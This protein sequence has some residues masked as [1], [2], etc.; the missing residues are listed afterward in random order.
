MYWLHYRWVTVIPDF[1]LNFLWHRIEGHFLI[2]MWTWSLVPHWS[3]LT[4]WGKVFVTSQWRV[5]L[6]ALLLTFV[7]IHAETLRVSFYS[8][9]RWWKVTPHWDYAGRV[10]V[11]LQLFS[12][13]SGWSKAV[14][15]CKF[16]VLLGFFF[17]V[18]WPK[19]EKAFVGSL[20]VFWSV[21]HYL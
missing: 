4:P 18:L 21:C 7:T 20:S 17:L 5:K 14:I 15:V 10:R 13:T 6:L 9:M 19:R 1:P 2:S 3:P 16:C 12:V 11:G 8:Q